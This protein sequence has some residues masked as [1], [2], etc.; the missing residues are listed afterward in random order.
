[1]TLPTLSFSYVFIKVNLE[2]VYLFIMFYYLI[3]WY[4]IIILL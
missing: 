1:M 2:H 3:S 4:F